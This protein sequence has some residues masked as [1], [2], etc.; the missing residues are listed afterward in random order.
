MK[1]ILTI[2]EQDINPQAPDLE[3]SAFYHRRA[4]RAIVLNDQGKVA[5]LKVNNRN[6]HKLPGGGIEDGEDEITALHRE[7]LEEIGCNAVV[8]SEVG[9]IVEYRNKW[10]LKQTSYGYLAK[11]DGAQ[12]E[13][14]FTEHEQEEGFEVV[15]ASSIDRAIA[16]LEQDVPSNYDG[17]F[18]QRRDLA[19]LRAAKQTLFSREIP[20]N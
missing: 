11:Q 6:Y 2:T 5:L 18:I 19:L 9:E 12:Q 4:S 13:V 3:T 10:Q 20:D 1:K 17:H 14:A 16:L 7:L 15:W 8:V